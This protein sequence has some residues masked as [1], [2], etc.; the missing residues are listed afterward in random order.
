MGERLANGNA[1]L[2]LLAN[3]LATGFALAALILAFA[4][5]SGAHF[6]PLVTLLAA[7]RGELAWAVVPG[8]LCAQ[9]VGAVL[10]VITAHTMF[11]EAL[12]ELSTRA[13]TGPAQWWS[14]AV[15]AF[16]LILILLRCAPR[17]V[18]ITAAAVAGYIAAAYWFTASTAFANPAVTFARAFTNTFSGIRA[19]DVPPF[20]VAQL[21]GA[22][23]AALAARW[24][25]S[26]ES[27]APAKPA[28]DPP[29]AAP[30]SH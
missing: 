16:G 20:I 17:G 1:A 7:W 5:V 23:I 22:L 24:M 21:S 18:P 15:A 8:Y 29:R 6:N 11:G 26:P 13:R 19:S 2:A 3:S 10:G 4:P 12:F 28:G 14:E 25:A 27:K 9:L 30:T